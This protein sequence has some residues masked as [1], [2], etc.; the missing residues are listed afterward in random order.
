MNTSA[1]SM[2]SNVHRSSDHQDSC[3]QLSGLASYG[4]SQG[5]AGLWKLCDFATSV[6]ENF[7]Y[8]SGNVTSRRLDPGRL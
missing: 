8:Q 3:L 5:C 7:A 6:A 1:V 2:Q 4:G